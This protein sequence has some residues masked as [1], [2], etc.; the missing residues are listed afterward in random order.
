MIRVMAAV[1]MAVVVSQGTWA[2][3]S[4]EDKAEAFVKSLG[5]KVVRDTSRLGQPIVAFDLG[6][7]QV[8]DAGLRNSECG[9]R[10]MML[11]YANHLNFKSY[12]VFIETLDLV[13]SYL[14]SCFAPVRARSPL[15]QAT[16]LGAGESRSASFPARWFAR[17]D[18]GSAR[19]VEHG[20][21]GTTRTGRLAGQGA[22]V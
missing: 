20:G 5:G 3:G 14:F 7:T 13:L 1:A 17:S 15:P 10:T 18:T 6:G 9:C 4:D 22:V 16:N 12:S 19:F 21:E 11:K 2:W 8:S